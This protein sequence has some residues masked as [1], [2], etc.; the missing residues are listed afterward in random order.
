MA[1]SW[2]ALCLHLPLLSYNTWFTFQLWA[3]R[4]AGGGLGLGG[5]K[6]EAQE[7]RRSCLPPGTT[8]PMPGKRINNKYLK[9][10]R[11]E[12]LEELSRLRRAGVGGAGRVEGDWAAWLKACL[13]AVACHYYHGLSLEVTSVLSSFNASFMVCLAGVSSPV[14]CLAA[15]WCGGVCVMSQLTDLPT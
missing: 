1:G 4:E 6:E 2:R 5:Q 10:L 13:Y 7:G 11:K 15:W 9:R 12:R 8:V 3:G 14:A